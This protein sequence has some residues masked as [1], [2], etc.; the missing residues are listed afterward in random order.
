MT[1]TSLFLTTC[2]KILTGTKDISSKK[3]LLVIADQIRSGLIELRE[4]YPE[5]LGRL[6]DRLLTELQVANTSSAL[7]AELRSR[8]KNIRDLGGDH[9]LEAFI[10]R[11]ANFHGSDEDMEGLA[12]M[13]INKP[14]QNWVDVDVDRA[15]VQLA[16]MAQKFVRI[17]AF[18][19]I[20]GRPNKRHAMAL[21]VGISGSPTT[22]HREFDITDRERDEVDELITRLVAVLE[23]SGEERR[24]VILATLTELSAKYLIPFS[25]TLEPVAKTEEQKPN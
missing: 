17:E 6:R 7:L 10:M 24:N 13:A 18:A 19:H 11:V 20:K 4:A 8:A 21:V 16:E 23:E 1:R 22:M 9:R 14:A 3:A 15:A 12:S 2:R 5:M 25:E